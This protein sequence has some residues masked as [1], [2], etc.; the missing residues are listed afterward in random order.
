MHLLDSLDVHLTADCCLPALFLLAC[1]MVPLFRCLLS[2]VVVL[3][4]QTLQATLVGRPSTEVGDADGDGR[5]DA[6]GPNDCRDADEPM[7]RR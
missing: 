7:A 4:A 5:T 1:V 2:V 3:L 6:A